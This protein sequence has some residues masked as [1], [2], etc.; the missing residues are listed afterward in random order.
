MTL[1]TTSPGAL[2][3]PPVPVQAR[4]A[5]AWTGFMFLYLYVDYLA[6]YKPGVVDD[7]LVGV[8]AEY[9][10]RHLADERLHPRP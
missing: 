4:L 1:R 10:P 3:T 6:L 7:I 9:G 2:D 8:D 5:A